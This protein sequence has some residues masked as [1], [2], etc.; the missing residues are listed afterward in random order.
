[1]TFNGIHKSHENCDSYT[2]KQI[3]LIMD[4]AIYV[5]FAILELSK[6]HVYETFYDKLQPFFGLKNLQ[7]HHIDT[8]GMILSMKTKN[9]ATIW[10]I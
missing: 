2:F 1:M 5:G 4:K 7:L 10:K 3:E 6:L 8:D 9:K